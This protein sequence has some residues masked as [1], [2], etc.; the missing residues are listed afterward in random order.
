MT[1]RP[2]PAAIDLAALRDR[3]TRCLANESPS[4][5]EAH[6]L[7]ATVLAALGALES[8]PAVGAPYRTAGRG[9]EADEELR[10]LGAHERPREEWPA[11][12]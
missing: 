2:N 1:P 7:A 10:S 12:R 11:K 3:A 9:A 4:A 6:E 8:E 5:A